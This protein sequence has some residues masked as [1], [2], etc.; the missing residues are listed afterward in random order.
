[1]R[2]HAGRVCRVNAR[3][4]PCRTVCGAW[5]EDMCTSG[6]TV[7]ALGIH[8]ACS[9]WLG[10]GQLRGLR[11]VGAAASIGWRRRW[12][13]VVDGETA[14]AG[15]PPK[16]WSP[17]ACARSALARGRG[18][19]SCRGRGGWKVGSW[20]SSWAAAHRR[21]GVGSEESEGEGVGQSCKDCLGFHPSLVS[22]SYRTK[23]I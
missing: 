16:P 23:G 15:L 1:M 8:G 10:R 7:H 4:M 6:N 11:P 18:K 12:P 3:S 5:G 20:G 19:V 13:V 21:L 14:T 9:T 17:R 2:R 22:I